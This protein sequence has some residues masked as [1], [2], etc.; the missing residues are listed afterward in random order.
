LFFLRLYLMNYYK[1]EDLYKLFVTFPSS[2]EF[3]LFVF[4]YYRDIV[5]SLYERYPSEAI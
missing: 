5:E 2:C 1:G 3:E 4:S